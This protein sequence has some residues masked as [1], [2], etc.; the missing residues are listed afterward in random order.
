MNVPF[1]DLSRAAA[2]IA[3]ELD[4]RWRGLLERT[5]FV[6][7]PEVA[8]FERA[9]ADYL[10]TTACAG[11]ANGT[12]ALVLALRALDLAPGDE[13][14]V[15][16]F[17]FVATASAVVMAGGRPVFA[18][19]EAATLNLDA[20]EVER[21][22]TERTVGVIGVHLYG[23]PFDVE[24]VGEVCRRYGLWL[25]EDAAQAHGASSHGRR[26]GRFGDLATWSFYPSKNLGAFGDGGAVTGEDRDRV[27]KVRLLANHGRA[28]H[29]HH[30]VVGTNSRLDGLQAAVLNCRLPRLERDNERRREIACHYHRGLSD[31]PGIRLLEDPDGALSVYHQMTIR[32]PGRRHELREFLASRGIGTGV[33]Y[34]EALHR[35]PALLPEDGEPPVLPVAE[36]AGGEVLCL[37]VFPELEDREV[38]AVIAEIR[39]F[40]GS[41]GA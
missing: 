13:V 29:Y 3:P 35:Q 34:P 4:E 18:D 12:D 7:G 30:V 32:V 24:G 2:R 37:P 40:P 22:R 33:H 19:V 6:G 26:V 23:R 25:V 16:A 1:F 17:T 9:F 28:E 11:V 21:R 10:G 36:A 38:D 14:I 31:L 8:E 5:A 20:E 27:E 15:P 41:T 39:A